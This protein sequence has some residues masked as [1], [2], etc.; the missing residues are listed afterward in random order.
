MK[1]TKDM[2][3]SMIKETMQK[4]AVEYDMAKKVFEGADKSSKYE[5]VIAILE[6]S[7]ADVQTIGIMSGQNPMAQASSPDD[8]KR[9]K[10]GLEE[11]LNELGLEF[12]RIGGKFMGIFE[13]SVL[14]LN[15][16]DEDQME[17]LNREYTQWGFVFGEKHPIDE[18]KSFMIFTMYEV[19]YDNPMGHR[20][21]PGSK[22]VGKPIRN[23][24]M[25]STD[26]NYSYIPG[27]GNPQ[28]GD[29]KV[30]KK[31]GLEL[32]EE[33][34]APNSMMEAMKISHEAKTRGKKV[35][36]IRGKK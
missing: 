32:Y 20:K 18:E 5:D 4:A 10:A 29:P 25:A 19:D 1:I 21:A 12:I 27:K 13:Q 22:Q 31:F 17:V 14:I 26:D 28:G 7:D 24:D 11:R 3:K 23:K 35:R 33:H 6:G 15:P 9:L 2:L 8:N 16:Q 36:F 30:K 34:P